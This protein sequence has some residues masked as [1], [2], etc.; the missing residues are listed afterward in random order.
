MIVFSSVLSIFILIVVGY[1]ARKEDI[2]DQPVI[3]GMSNFVIKVTLPFTII[4]SFDRSIPLSAMPDLIRVAI[5]A[6]F[7]QVF[8]IAFSFFV[9]RKIE[10]RT[11]K[12][13]SFVTVFSNCGFMGF[14]VAESVFGK[15]GVMYSSIFVIVFQIFLWTYGISLF[16]ITASKNQI[17][18]GIFNAG[19]IA[20][21]IGITIWILPFDLP[22]AFTGAINNISN[23]TT[24]LSMIIVGATLANISLKGILIGGSLWFGTVIRLIFMPLSIFALMR[25]LGIS[26]MP[27][28]VVL[29]LLSMPAAAQTVLFAER[30]EADVV[31]ASRIVSVT[32]ILSIVSIPIFTLLLNKI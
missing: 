19:N 8:A 2:L 6:V 9:Y 20:L 21:L 31:L 23:V 18:K 28:K 5:L 32:T 4:A 14:P 10:T 26:G 17:I 12:V 1:L 25:L 16:S 27:A 30:Y 11:R 29:L 15:I 3:R 13:L 24:P 7:V 22:K